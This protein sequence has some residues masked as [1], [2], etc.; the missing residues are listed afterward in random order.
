MVGSWIAVAV[1][2]KKS[3][4]V[5]SVLHSTVISEWR[6]LN[7]GQGVASTYKEIYHLVHSQAS[8]PIVVQQGVQRLQLVHAATL[9]LKRTSITFEAG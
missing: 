5:D 1:I 9:E 7:E 3:I 6:W 4:V 2:H 8:R